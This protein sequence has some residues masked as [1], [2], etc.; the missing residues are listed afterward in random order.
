MLYLDTA[1]LG[2][3]TPT[4]HRALRDITEFNAEFGA[5]VLFDDLLH[6]GVQAL[7]DHVR[8]RYAGLQSWSGI[9]ETRRIIRQF[10]GSENSR[11]A[12]SS[13]TSELMAVAARLQFSRCRRVLVTD[14]TWPAYEHALQHQAEKRGGKIEVVSLRA[15]IHEDGKDS[16]QIVQQLVK[17]FEQMNCDGLFLP[18]ISHHG[19]RLPVERIVAAIRKRCD[20]RFVTVDAAQA[21]G[22]IDV[23]PLASVADFLLF[24]THKWLRSFVPFGIGHYGRIESRRFIGDSIQRWIQNEQITDPVWRFI[25]GGQ[26]EKFGETVNLAAL[27]TVAG[28]IQDAREES[29]PECSSTLRRLPSPIADW[30]RVETSKDLESKIVLFENKKKAEF[31]AELLKQRFTRQGV[32][33]TTYAGGVVRVSLPIAGLDVESTS[34]LSR[35][36]EMV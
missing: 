36:L 19:V 7:P 14:L 15:S 34:V 1:R 25:D 12:L 35:A 18:A 30:Q 16:E 22:Q 10:V 20:V 9:S 21:A 27:F 4:A 31:D 32:A 5:S 33:V 13:R 3:I 17:R 26:R 6:G 24:G 11:I 8:H 29:R 28:A 23:R 2:Q